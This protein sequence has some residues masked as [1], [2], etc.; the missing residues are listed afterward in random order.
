LAPRLSNRSKR[1]TRCQSRAEIGS[2]LA[3]PD[4]DLGQ[5]FGGHAR[6]KTRHRYGTDDIT[7][8]V[9]ARTGDTGNA[10]AAILIV[11]RVALGTRIGNLPAQSDRAAGQRPCSAVGQGKNGLD[12]VLGIG[13]KHGF[14]HGRVD[15]PGAP[16]RPGN[17]AHDLAA[18][19]LCHHHDF[20]IVQ[21]TEIGGLPGKIAQMAQMR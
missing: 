21:N 11:Y 3:D 9:F 13:R 10:L 8:C 16:A 12:L 17:G 18:L 19:G 5:A 15:Q 20:P 14:A 2:S 4:A 6:R 1:P 7:R